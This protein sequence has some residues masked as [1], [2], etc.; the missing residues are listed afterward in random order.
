MYKHNFKKNY[1]Q[2]FIS[3]R[4]FINLLIDSADISREDTVIEIGPGNGAVTEH[5]LTK[6]AKVIAIEVDKDLVP[7]LSNKFNTNPNFR[8]INSDFLYFD[9]EGLHLENYK[10]VA[11]LPYNISKRI[12][13]KLL[14]SRFKPSIMSL[15]IQ[16]EVAEDYCSNP[17]NAK[18]LANYVKVFGE[19]QYIKTVPKKFFYPRPKVDG[20]IIKIT[21]EKDKGTFMNYPGF[22]KFLKD[23]YIHPRKKL[24]SVLK[25]MNCSTKIGFEKV[26]NYLKINSNAR[27][28]ELSFEQWQQ[29]YTNLIMLPE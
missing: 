6:G 9:L 3:N 14:E 23:S 19:S 5:L 16:K 11:S 21:I 20:A 17:P 28:Q 24:I 7:V 2:N 1:G 18:F 10:I 27:P 4:K 15:I 25:R 26:F 12:I 13:K 29:L 22:I 8:L